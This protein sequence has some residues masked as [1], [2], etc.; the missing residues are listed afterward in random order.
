MKNKYTIPFIALLCFANIH[1]LNAQPVKRVLL[2]EMSTTLC[3]FCPVKSI[4]GARFEVAHPNAIVITHHAGF[5]TDAMTSTS[6]SVFAAAFQPYHFPSGT[7]DR[8]KFDSVPGYYTKYVGVSLMAF[9]WQDTML[10][11]LNNVT[12]KAVVGIEKTWNASTREISGNVK[13]EFLTAV[14]PGDLRI[15]LYIVEDSVVG[16][17]GS[18]KYD[19][20]NNYISDNTYPELYGKTLIREYVHRNVV[21]NAPLGDWGQSGIIPSNPVIN[22]PY[23]APFS[24]ILPEKYDLSKGRE[25]LAKHVYLVFFVSYFDTDTWKRKILNTVKVQLTTTTDVEDNNEVQSFNLYPNPANESARLEFNVNTSE[26]VSVVLIDLN[27]RKAAELYNGKLNIGSYSLDINT[28][29]IKPG[30]YICQ[31]RT[32]ETV[33]NKRLTIIH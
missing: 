20:K 24:Y 30:T 4:D 33:A 31:I 12:A 21:R 6:S 14:D 9:K 18:Y 23:S 7:I 5:G 28:S 29:L 3:S 19:Q 26:V 32:S 15:N 8:I 22:Q 2:E 1:F 11:I 10:S 16:D 25:V 17:T 13:V 27:G